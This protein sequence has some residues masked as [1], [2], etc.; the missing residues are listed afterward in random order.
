MYFLT[1]LAYNIK[2]RKK[3][4]NVIPH[5]KFWCKCWSYSKVKIPFSLDKFEFE[6]K[7]IKNRLVM[8]LLPARNL[9]KLSNTN[10]FNHFENKTKKHNF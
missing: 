2:E 8:N 1:G 5:Y 7:L 3:G 6:F 10:K 4:L 9:K